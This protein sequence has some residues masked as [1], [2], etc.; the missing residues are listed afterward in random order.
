MSIREKFNSFNFHR[1]KMQITVL[2]CC[3]STAAVLSFLKMVNLA[4]PLKSQPWFTT[5][6]NLVSIYTAAF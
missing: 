2:V 5:T 4:Q 6:L 3:G 1:Y